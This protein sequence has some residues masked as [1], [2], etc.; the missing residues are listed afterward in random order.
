MRL[1]L[2]KSHLG[3]SMIGLYNQRWKNDCKVIVHVSLEYEE[4][5]FKKGLICEFEIAYI[6]SVSNCLVATS[7][8]EGL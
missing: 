3:R 4:Y 5:R 7:D 6:A 1:R 2:A 8:A